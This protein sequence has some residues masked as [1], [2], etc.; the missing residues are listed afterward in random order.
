MIGSSGAPSGEEM[1]GS[2]GT[3][4]WTFRTRET[5]GRIGAPSGARGIGVTANL[6]AP[7]GTEGRGIC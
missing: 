7:S 5:I 6:G 2:S 3:G 1:I 4:K